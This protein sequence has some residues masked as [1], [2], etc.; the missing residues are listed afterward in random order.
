MKAFTLALITAVIWGTAPLFEKAGLRGV[1]PVIGVMIRGLGVTVCI[2]LFLLFSGG[3]NQIMSF[4]KKATAL[5]LFGGILASFFGQIFF[6]QALKLG[7]A[8]RVVPV[9]GMYPL[10]TFILGILVFNEAVTIPKLFGVLCILVGLFF[11]R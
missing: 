11:I 5:I 2:I 7:E 10:V 4:D 8:S 1:D 9:S 3:F 6:Y